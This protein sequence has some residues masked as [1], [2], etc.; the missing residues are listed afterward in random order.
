MVLLE[1][2][3]QLL[4]E[5][6]DWFG[7]CQA[8]FPAEI[9]C[10]KGCSGCCRGLF[11]I[12]ILD[13]AFLKSGFDK[14]PGEVKHG[15]RDKAEKRLIHIQ[16][17]WPE[18]SQP[19]TLNHRPEPEIEA[20]M[21]SDNE[22]PCVLLDEN[23]RCLL[24]DNRPMTCRLHG[25]PLIDISGEVMEA[26]WCTRNFTGSNPL[27]LK[28]LR[29]EFK[30]MLYQEVALGRNFT[31]ELLG[32]AVSELDTFI[33]TALLINFKEFDWSE[34]FVRSLSDLGNQHDLKT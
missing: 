31:N 2:Y 29:G 1:D 26:E 5:I 19:F 11:D 3:S 33:P 28:S 34:W 24:Y 20:L 17:I 25:L 4:A 16:S 32:K 9:A 12:T 14:L 18:F 6:D 23:G 21:A 10:G 22:T 13:A 30:R 7:R 15:V 8:S 27:Q